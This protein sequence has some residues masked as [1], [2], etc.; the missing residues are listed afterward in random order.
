MRG[1]EDPAP[2]EQEQDANPDLVDDAEAM[3]GHGHEDPEGAG[4]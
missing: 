3:S 2:T 4:S 1:D